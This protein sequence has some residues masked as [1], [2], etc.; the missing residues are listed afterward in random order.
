MKVQIVSWKTLNF[1]IKFKIIILENRSKK[2]IN[3]TQ[4][5]M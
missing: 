2:S 1:K 5:I 3:L 4:L